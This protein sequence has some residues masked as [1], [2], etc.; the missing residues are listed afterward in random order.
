M[1]ISMASDVSPSALSMINL[2]NTQRRD[3]ALT[4]AELCDYSTDL[5]VPAL[6]AMGLATIDE[7]G[8]VHSSTD[9]DGVRWWSL[10]RVSA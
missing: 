9:Q 8:A 3:A 7:Q 10:S 2:T 6:A 1:V 5:V 4:I